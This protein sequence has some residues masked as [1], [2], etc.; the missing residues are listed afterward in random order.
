MNGI[1]DRRF[2]IS[3]A[4]MFVLTWA[5]AFVV[6]NGLLASSYAAH[7]NVW[8]PMADAQ[9]MWPIFLIAHFCTAL[10]FSW[11]YIKGKEDKPWLA[12]GVRYGVAVAVLV[13]VPLYLIYYVVLPI[14]FSLALKQIIYDT[15]R[16]VLMGVVLA[17]LNR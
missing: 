5:L 3:V 11:I 7:P 4:V 9:R 2:L 6:H 16:F 10:A 8:R 1:L 14:S 15:I 12:Q 13:I 17:W